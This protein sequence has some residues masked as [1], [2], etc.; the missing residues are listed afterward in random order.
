MACGLLENAGTD[1]IQV[2][3]DNEVQQ[4]T[5]LCQTALEMYSKGRLADAIDTWL[6]ATQI[7]PSCSEAKMRL[8]YALD[9]KQGILDELQE[10]SQQVSQSP[11]DAAAHYRIAYLM[12]TLGHDDEARAAWLRV[13]Q[14]D[15]G[16]WAKSSRKMLRKHLAG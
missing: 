6:K 2:K 11:H 4:A 13:M 1:K 7:D 3:M 12:F 9:E 14:V 16:T 8:G 10:L 5:L 15:D